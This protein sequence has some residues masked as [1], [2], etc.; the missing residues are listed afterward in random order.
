M[1]D[2]KN[3]LSWIAGDSPSMI[4]R[5]METLKIAHSSIEHQQPH[6]TRGSGA[7]RAKT[8][9]LPNGE[10][11]HV[12]TR[13]KYNPRRMPLNGVAEVERRL[14]QI[15]AGQIKVANGLVI[16]PKEEPKKA[17]R[18]ANGRF[19]ST[20]TTGNKPAPRKRAPRKTVSQKEI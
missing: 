18:G 14:R 20:T 6:R 7:A 8:F 2:L 1:P 17:R 13:S 10:L 15:A 16:L 4:Q 3:A 5:I 11:L 9:R 19:A 12:Y